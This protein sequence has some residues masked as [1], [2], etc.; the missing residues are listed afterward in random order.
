[1]GTTPLSSFPR[2][3]ATN[4]SIQR[5]KDFI[6]SGVI[7]V[8][9]SLPASQAP[10]II[11]PSIAPGFCFIS[12]VLQKFAILIAPSTMAFISAPHMAAGT[13]P[14]YERAENLPP[15]FEGFMKIFLNFL[16][17]PN[18]SSDEPLSV[19]AIKWEPGFFT[20]VF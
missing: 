19:M 6:L 15:M 13:K 14:K 16:A 9:L 11:A 4:C 5:V 1:M 2:L 12:E 18:F 20:F 8:N 10:A 7:T 3:S 17:S